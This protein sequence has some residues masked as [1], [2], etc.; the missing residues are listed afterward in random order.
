VLDPADGVVTTAARASGIPDATIEAARRSPVLRFVK[1][2]EVALPLHP[3]YRTLP[4]VFYVPPLLPAV[5]GAAAG[6][7][8]TFFG[9]L[10]TARLPIRYLASLFAAGNEAQVAAAYRKL[11][12]VRVHRRAR[13]VG[14]VSPAAA[15]RALGDAG[16]TPESADAL[17]RLTALA[18]MEER[19]VLPGLAR[20]LETEPAEEPQAR[21]A[22]G[23]AYLRPPRRSAGGAR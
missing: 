18:P 2:W 17:Y 11:I 22:D 12:A 5:A 13:Q 20:E 23:L 14:D 19:I 8:E 6:E 1:E 4:M 21:G 16:L 3:E 15:A 7:G 9:G 10:E